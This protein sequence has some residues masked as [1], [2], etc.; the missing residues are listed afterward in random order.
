[1]S[2]DTINIKKT[3]FINA[4]VGAVFRFWSDFRNF[5]SFIWL[6]ERV[7]ILDQTRSRWVIKAPLGKKVDFN[8]QI[9]ELIED[10]SLIWE[11]RHFA[12]DSRGDIKFTEHGHGTHVQLVFSYSIKLGW[13]HRI[14]KMMHRL[15]FPSVSF[16]EGLRKIKKEIERNQMLAL[17]GD[18]RS[19]ST[20]KLNGP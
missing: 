10:K 3:I 1:M 13:V 11:S 18:E 19:G 20:P 15:G 6:I 12:V 16:D 7:E 2:V 8:S 17:K 14:A 9:T 4:P 5:P